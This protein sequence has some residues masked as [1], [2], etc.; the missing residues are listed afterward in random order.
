MLYVKYISILNIALKLS[1][2]NTLWHLF[3]RSDDSII[4]YWIQEENIRYLRGEN[5]QI[6]I[7]HSSDQENHLFKSFR[8]Q[9]FLNWVS[10]QAPVIHSNDKWDPTIFKLTSKISW[11][12]SKAYWIW[13]S[14]FWMMKLGYFELQKCGELGF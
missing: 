12:G 4:S 11:L 7:W 2:I 10:W 3:I 8:F 6:M 5:I 13:T 1:V 9:C 14:T